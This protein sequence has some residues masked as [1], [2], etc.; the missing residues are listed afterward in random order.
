MA[1]EE[2]IKANRK[3][4]RI[5]CVRAALL[6]FSKAKDP[7]HL[8]ERELAQEGTPTMMTD[9]MADMMHLCHASAYGF[10]DILRVARGHFEEEGGKYVGTK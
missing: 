8:P 7:R 1:T 9:L 4:G 2:T 10:E 3:K 5:K 6:A